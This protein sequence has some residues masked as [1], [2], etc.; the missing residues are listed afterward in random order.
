MQGK[1]NSDLEP[2]VPHIL[3]PTSSGCG[4]EISTQALVLDEDGELK[5]SFAATPITAE[6]VII[7]PMLAL[8]VPLHQT[9]QGA[10]S[11]LGQCIESYLLGCVDHE[12]EQIAL[13][14][15][16]L[17]ATAFAQP[18]VEGKVNLKD[19]AFREL[20][21]LASLASGISANSSGRG[22]AHAIA[23]SMGGVSDVPHAHVASAFLP[24]VFDHYATLA[25]ENEGDDF[26][27]ELREKLERV[28]DRLIAGSGFQG[29]SVA[30][31][32]RYV[33]QRFALPNASTLELDEAVIKGI[34]DRAA[35]FQDDDLVTRP[36]EAI[37]EKDDIRAIVD[38]AVHVVDP[39]A[40]EGNT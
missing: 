26:F 39:P 29:A 2:A 1:M 33:A 16:D 6:A 25:Q 23:V 27:D 13:Q 10:L 20:L 21:A 17:I 24:F 35:Q 28:G 18:L 32:L 9:V 14:G 34:V 37:L 40:P 30:A 19:V 38:N 31:W 15:I 7:D 12:A 11:G 8:T 5:Q 22:V 36:H 4:A 3:V